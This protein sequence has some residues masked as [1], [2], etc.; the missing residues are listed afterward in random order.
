MEQLTVLK[1]FLDHFSQSSR[2]YA[3]ARPTYPDELFRRVAELSPSSDAAWDCAT[4]NGQAARGLARYFAHVEATDA[5]AQQIE[6]ASASSN[7]T[8]SVQ[9]A[10]GTNFPSSTF[11]AVCVAQALHWFDVG[12]FHA[13]VKRVLKP[14]GLLLVVGYGWSTYTPRFER[15]FMREVIEP[16]R[17]YWPPQ[18]KLLWDGYRDLP[19]PF[20]PVAFPKM[21]IEADWTLAQVMDYV[22]TWTAT[23]RLAEGDPGFLARAQAR[24]AP[25]WGEDERQ[26]VTFPLHIQCGRHIPRQVGE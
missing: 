13:E 8:Y 25:A 18:N 12:R 23:R 11:D 26:R 3:Q 14:R 9:P 20:E 21:V 2:E 5:S 24:L 6:H 17:P 7:I 4:G 16:V 1:P 15:E 10:E 19:F 22:A